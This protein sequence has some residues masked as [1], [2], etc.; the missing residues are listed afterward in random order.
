ML[1]TLLI[2]IRSV[3]ILIGSSVL[4]PPTLFKT[5]SSCQGFVNTISIKSS[6]LPHN[7]DSNK[8]WFS[9]WYSLFLLRLHLCTIS[10]SNSVF[11]C[12]FFFLYFSKIFLWSQRK[13]I[14]QKLLANVSTVII[15][16]LPYSLQFLISHMSFSFKTKGIFAKSNQLAS[17][18][19]LLKTQSLNLISF[20]SIQ[21]S[22]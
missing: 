9:I 5:F 7:W 6:D 17:F 22:F 21:G 18:A 8:K 19:C 16:I 3:T 14:R 20:C 1:C 11:C 15:S 12:L 13:Y 4:L 10:F 2:L